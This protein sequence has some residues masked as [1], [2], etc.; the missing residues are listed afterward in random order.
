MRFG[1]IVLWLGAAGLA[2]ACSGNE[3]LQTSDGC[4]INTD[5][6][7]PLVCA[8]K[9]C[10]TQC[11][12]TRDCPQGER[13]VQVLEPVT[14]AKLGSV[15]Q[16]PDEAQPECESA[17]NCPGEEICGVDGHCRDQCDTDA[18][19]IA[20][21]VC[22]TRTCADPAELGDAGVLPS[23][24][25]G[26]YTRSGEPL[27]GPRPR[28]ADA[29]ATG[30]G[31]SSVTAGS[32]GA[33]LGGSGVG[34]AAVNG[35]GAGSGGVADGGSG[36]IDSGRPTATLGFAPSNFDLIPASLGADSGA[37][38][39]AGSLPS[40]HISQTTCD[41]TCLPP[42]IPLT[43][44]DGSPADLYLVRSLAIDTTAVLHLSGPRPIVIAALETAD[45]Q[46]TLSVG[47]DHSDGG[48]GG[49]SYNVIGPGSGAAGVSATT[50][51]SGGGGGSYCGVGGTGWAG[52]GGLALAGKTYGTPEIAPLV[53]GSPGGTAAYARG[54]GGG[55][56]IQIVARGS[57]SVGSFG[58][59][60]AGGAGGY[61]ASP[62]AAGGSGGAILLEA[63][64][65]TINGHLAANGGAGAGDAANGDP[66]STSDIP[67]AGGIN[68]GGSGS[69]G[70]T[71]NGANGIAASGGTAGGGG[72]GRIRINTSTGMPAL[73]PAAIVS[74]SFA[75]PCATKGKLIGY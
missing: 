17:L 22:A 56:A 9:R 72:A 39:D 28:M 13:C 70:D 52:S 71:I 8:F 60:Y 11:K 21:Q 23:V 55:G 20:G 57:I 32:G 14:L 62:S 26:G 5:C 7:N 42:A 10:H 25:E 66:A 4:S 64:A 68:G 34:G 37:S 44:V 59:V 48:P 74:P 30:V 61:E 33:G 18:D 67:A 35:G 73:G 27:T 15:C 29:S 31:G 1:R 51:F 54:G 40:T 41:N 24:I 45:I 3:A 38:L 36:P 65:I 47:A 46:G 58:I 43:M 50:P 19:C 53:G 16:L 75:T 12:A 2:N 69:H 63:P 6:N 49:F